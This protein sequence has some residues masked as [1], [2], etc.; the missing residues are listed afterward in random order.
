MKLSDALADYFGPQEDSRLFPLIADAVLQGTKATPTGA[1]SKKPDLLS[2]GTAVM[3]TPEDVKTTHQ[4]GNTQLIRSKARA[5]RDAVERCLK[6]RGL[7]AATGLYLAG[8]NKTPEGL[9]ILFE[10]EARQ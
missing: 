3:V 10:M 1:P 8:V 2:I 5:A 7:T 6:K 4:L 9:E